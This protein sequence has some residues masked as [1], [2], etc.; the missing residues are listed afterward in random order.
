MPNTACGLPSTIMASPTTTGRLRART[1]ISSGQSRDT[2]LLRGAA[3]FDNLA[4]TAASSMRSSAA[5]ML[6]T[7]GASTASVPHFRICR[8]PHVRVSIPGKAGG[9]R[10]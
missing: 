2:L 7:P 6:V 3:D 9:L 8:P 5:A 1:A 10:N 4:P